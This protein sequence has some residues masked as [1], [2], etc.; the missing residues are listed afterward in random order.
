MQTG[1]RQTVRRQQTETAKEEEDGN[2]G[3]RQGQQRKAGIGDEGDESRG[4]DSTSLATAID[5]PTLKP[6]TKPALVASA[7]ASAN[8]TATTTTSFTKAATATNDKPIANPTLATKPHPQSVPKQS[9]QR[10]A[11][12]DPS[13]VK[14]PSSPTTNVKPTLRQSPRKKPSKNSIVKQTPRPSDERNTNAA[15]FKSAVKYAGNST[16][17]RSALSSATDVPNTLMKSKKR[18][19]ERAAKVTTKLARK[20]VFNGE[21]T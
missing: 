19:N 10:I 1:S 21:H 8:T 16:A 12:N 6:T 5:L 11:V 13:S 7:T 17:K 15:L 20:D 18:E 14:R 2:K 9:R 3:E 4:D